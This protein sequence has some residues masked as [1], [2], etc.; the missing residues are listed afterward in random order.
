MSLLALLDHTLLGAASRLAL[1]ADDADDTTRSFTFG[2]LESRSNRWAQVLYARGIRRGDR[3]AFL[4][5]NCIEIIDL[6]L[7][8]V[9]LGVIV[10]PVCE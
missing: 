10:V 6:W 4:L 9:K 3:L 8:C 7:A 1:D 2:E 5:P